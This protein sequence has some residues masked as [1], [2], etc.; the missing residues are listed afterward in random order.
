V[1]CI[2]FVAW[3]VHCARH[4]SAAVVY[5]F[6]LVGRRGTGTP[7]CACCCESLAV[8]SLLPGHLPHLAVPSATSH[9]RHC[10]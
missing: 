2:A 7:G 5:R 4:A 1:T 3:V 9:I 10:K 8:C 6:N